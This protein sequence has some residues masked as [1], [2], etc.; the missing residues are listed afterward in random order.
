MAKLRNLTHG[1]L[2]QPA[3]PKLD[4][5]VRLAAVVL[6]G[7]YRDVD[8]KQEIIQGKGRYFFEGGG[9]ELWADMIHQDYAVCMA[10]YQKVLKD[11][12]PSGDKRHDRY[13]K[14]Q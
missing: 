5:H 8:D 7:G 11:G 3:N 9:F 10:G 4:P 13:R 2:N 12:L 1:T 14:Y 6:A